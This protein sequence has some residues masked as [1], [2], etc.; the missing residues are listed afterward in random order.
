MPMPALSRARTAM[1]ADPTRKYFAGTDRDRA[2]FEAGIKLGSIVHQYVGTPPT[3][4]P[5]PAD[6]D[7][8]L[9]ARRAGLRDTGSL[10]RPGVRPELRR[11][12]VH[13][14]GVHGARLRVPGDRGRISLDPPIDARPV[15]LP[16]R[17]DVVVW[18][19]HRRV[20]LHLRIRIRHRPRP[21]DDP[22]YSILGPLRPR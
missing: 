4:G 12:H 5:R 21:E 10:A 7:A 20:V 14:D 3:S 6:R 9:P 17:L 16:R 19:L 8:D 1:A 15:G 18:P 22:R 2:A 13:R 11:D